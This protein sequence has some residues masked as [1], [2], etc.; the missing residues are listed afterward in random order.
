MSNFP[1]PEDLLKH[2]KNLL[3]AVLQEIE[4]YQ[5][6]PKAGLGPVKQ[7]LLE[8]FNNPIIKSLSSAPLTQ[9]GD[10]SHAN[11]TSEL[12]IIKTSPQQL[13][14]AVSGLQSK[15]N[16]NPTVKAKPP[17][18]NATLAV[19]PTPTYLAVARTRPQNVSI[20]LDLAQTKSAHAFRPRPVEVCRLINDTLMASSHEQVRISTIRW[21]VK[22]NL[23]VIGG[24][25]VMLHH[26]QLAMATIAQAFTTS[27]SA[28]VNPFPP[29]TQA[30][31]KWSKILINGL[32]TG[33]SDSR[34]VFTPDEC[35][36]TLTANNP[37]YAS[38]PVMQKP[39][40]VRPPPSYKAGSSSS[41][42][43]A[44]EDL[45]GS[46]LKSLL[47][48]RHLYAFGTRATVKKW[49]QRTP[50]HKPT[51]KNDNIESEDKDEVKILTR[52]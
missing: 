33:T 15:V 7:I 5:K 45:D 24:H 47:A 29:P 52:A 19:P 32:P 18:G 40:W 10:T 1:T 25:N 41:L 34:E 30:N 4:T 16:N 44:F 27:Y 22:G 2:I 9:K 6:L 38:L 48:A 12:A 49:K 11:H 37:S 28:A 26:L 51:S 23:V 20:I 13:N 21:T 43:F 35:H 3:I 39:S 31:V 36:Q 42:I 14:K 50:Q 17:R 8:F 46:R